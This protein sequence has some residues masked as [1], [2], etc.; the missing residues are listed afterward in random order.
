MPL[1]SS[2]KK[3]A[4][5]DISSI[6]LKISL[7]VPLNNWQKRSLCDFHVSRLLLFAEP[8]TFWLRGRVLWTKLYARSGEDEIRMF[9]YQKRNVEEGNICTKWEQ[10]NMHWSHRVLGEPLHVFTNY[11]NWFVNISFEH[12]LILFPKMLRF[13]LDYTYWR[14]KIKNTIPFVFAEPI[15]CMTGV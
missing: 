5:N 4:E 2:E 12:F 14:F 7:W 15:F 8:H 6:L 13:F 11:W 9:S 10:F 1:K 3:K